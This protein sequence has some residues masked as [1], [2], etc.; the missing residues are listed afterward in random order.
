MIRFTVENDLEKVM[1]LIK[2]VKKDLRVRNLDIWKDDYPSEEIIINDLKNN[3]IVK[4]INN[5][6][7]GYMAIL[8]NEVDIFEETFSNHDNFLFVTRVMVDPNYRRLGIAK[9]LFEYAFNLNYNSYRITVS[10]KNTNAYKLYESLGFKYVA[11][12]TYPWDTLDLFE[13]GK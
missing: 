3:S 1:K 9:E 10:S 6:I 11:T 4:I 2:N 8:K 12:K 7:V 13:K 5:E